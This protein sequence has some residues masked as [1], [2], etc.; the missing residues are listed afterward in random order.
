MPRK[1]KKKSKTTQNATSVVP[2]AAYV[3]S[4]FPKDVTIQQIQSYLPEWLAFKNAF[5]LENLQRRDENT[6]SIHLLFPEKPLTPWQDAHLGSDIYEKIFKNRYRIIISPLRSQNHGSQKKKSKSKSDEFAREFWSF[7]TTEKDISICDRDQISILL[8]EF[9]AAKG[10]SLSSRRELKSK[11]FMTMTS[12]RKLRLAQTQR[13]SN[14]TVLTLFADPNDLQFPSESQKKEERQRLKVQMDEAHANKGGVEISEVADRMIGSIGEA[15]MISFEVKVD[16]PKKLR[17]IASK[18]Q[19]GSMFRIP[20]A[21]ASALPATVSSPGFTFDVTVTPKKIGVLRAKIHFLF[22][23]FV[24]VRSITMSCGDKKILEV[25]QPSTPYQRKKTK[26]IKRAAKDVLVPPKSNASGSESNPFRALP[27]YH[28]P[29][30]ISEKI[31]SKDS[32]EFDE[33]MSSF[34]WQNTS[35]HISAEDYGKYWQHLLYA[36]EHQMKRDIQVRTCLRLH[37]KRSLALYYSILFAHIFFL[38]V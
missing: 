34:S 25:L 1:T 5:K 9:C 33:L 22:D 37:S 30:Q 12:L 17:A 23:G 21:I 2:N 26:Y 15:N 19:H 32:A 11:E 7:V 4:G 38:V 36:G 6:S 31:R 8:Q 13:S 29:A 10:L 35:S 18:G 14:F 28:V 3:L 24:I 16:G 27:Q 20:D